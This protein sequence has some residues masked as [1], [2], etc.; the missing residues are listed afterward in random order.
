MKKDSGSIPRARGTHAGILRKL[1]NK[2]PLPEE[3]LMRNKNR[4][5]NQIT[6]G[7]DNK[8]KQKGG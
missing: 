5:R 7:H 4:E 6:E 3:E 8:R 1:M 2:E